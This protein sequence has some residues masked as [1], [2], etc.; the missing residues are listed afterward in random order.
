MFEKLSEIIGLLLGLR[1]FIIMLI[2]VGVG[3]IFRIKNYLSGDNFTDLM[4]ATTIAFFASNSM[5]HFKKAVTTFVDS[6]V[7]KVKQID[8]SIGDDPDAK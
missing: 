1:K 2:L 7:Q 8:I 4:K 5:E 3:I 6:K